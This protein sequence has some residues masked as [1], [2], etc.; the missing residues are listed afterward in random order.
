MDTL[1]DEVAIMVLHKHNGDK[2]KF[3]ESSNGYYDAKAKSQTDNY[4]CI[5]SV[6]EKSLY[7]Q[8]QLKNADLVAKW[9]S[10][11]TSW[12][13]L[14]CHVHQDDLREPVAKLPHHRQ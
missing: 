6:N 13:P 3:M 8:R 14:P 2:M 5:H 11:Q 12:S 10:L 9:L 4:S 7:T 1:V